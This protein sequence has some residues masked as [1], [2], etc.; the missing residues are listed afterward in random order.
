MTREEQLEAAKI[1]FDTLGERHPDHQYAVGGNLAERL[2]GLTPLEEKSKESVQIYRPYGTPPVSRETRKVVEAKLKERGLDKARVGYGEGALE[3][4]PKRH[5]SGIP[6]VHDHDLMKMNI[7]GYV[8]LM[9]MADETRNSAYGHSQRIRNEY[10]ARRME[11]DAVPALVTLGHMANRLGAK[12]IDSALATSSTPYNPDILTQYLAKGLQQTR[13][14]GLARFDQQVAKDTRR[15]ILDIMQNLRRTEAAWAATDT[16]RKQIA[17][18]AATNRSKLKFDKRKQQKDR[19][20]LRERLYAA[21]GGGAVRAQ[22]KYEAAKNLSKKASDEASRAMRS[23]RNV[24]MIGAPI[25]GRKADGYLEQATWT[26]SDGTDAKR[27]LA[28]VDE[29]WDSPEGYERLVQARQNVLTKA[30]PAAAFARPADFRTVT[31]G[32]TEPSATRTSDTVDRKKLVEAARLSEDG[33]WQRQPSDSPT[34]P[35]NARPALAW[36]NSQGSSQ[37]ENKKASLRR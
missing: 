5:S 1:V 31:L 32:N 12:D 37:G 9:H 24:A 36:K 16:G 11:S 34:L 7:A 35:A 21:F 26:N 20:S 6:L 23:F 25:T 14:D 33:S 18:E 27:I 10:R 17:S 29:T 3:Y 22:A 4:R 13:A 30:D 8:T 28:G 19:G 2:A 15:G